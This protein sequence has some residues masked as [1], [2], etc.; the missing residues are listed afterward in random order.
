MTLQSLE[1]RLPK[2]KEQLARVAN[3][4]RALDADVDERV[5]DEAVMM[6]RIAF[7]KKR[8]PQISDDLANLQ[9]LRQILADFE[10]SPSSTAKKKTVTSEDENSDSEDGD[11]LD[12]RQ[13]GKRRDRRR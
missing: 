4:I 12:R 11:S 9:E 8:L 2:R 13:T 1:K 6:E 3:Q 10:P 7:L 5:Y